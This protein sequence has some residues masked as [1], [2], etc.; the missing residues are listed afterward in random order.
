MNTSVGVASKVD[1]PG[2]PQ[3]KALCWVADY[4]LLM[5]SVQGNNIFALLQ[6]YTMGVIYF[7]LVS[8]NGDKDSD[9]SLTNT[10]FLSP[11]HEC[12]WGLV[13]CGTQQT[14]TA[15]LME[16]KMLRGPFPVEIANL[17]NLCKCALA[18]VR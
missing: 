17:G 12:E 6:R 14:V 11:S 7:S 3:R 15:L 13:L 4:D 18:F 16:D 5:V 2:S 8:E 9:R 10:D 1:T